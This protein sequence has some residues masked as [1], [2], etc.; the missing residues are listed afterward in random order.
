MP[1]YEPMIDLKFAGEHRHKG[2][3]F[4]LHDP[5]LNRQ[6]DALVAHGMLRVVQES[7]NDVRSEES[8]SEPAEEGFA[9]EDHIDDSTKL[10]RNEELARQRAQ[11]RESK[12]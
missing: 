3:Q 4:E 7:E 6:V 10:S 9:I 8:V 11:H 12:K 2:E 5:E 1:R